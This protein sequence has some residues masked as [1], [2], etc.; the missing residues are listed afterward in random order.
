MSDYIVVDMFAD[1]ASGRLTAEEAAQRAEQRA[2]EY[3]SAHRP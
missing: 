3:Y 2:L 1:A